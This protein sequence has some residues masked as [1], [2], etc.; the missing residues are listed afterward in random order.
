MTGGYVA[1]CKTSTKTGTTGASKKKKTG[2]TV[3]M[4]AS[5]LP[6]VF[7]VIDGVGIC[8][9]LF[10]IVVVGVIDFVGMISVSQG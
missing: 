4:K 3:N 9:C 5:S 1:G 6:V 8:F 7:V 10:V 2:T